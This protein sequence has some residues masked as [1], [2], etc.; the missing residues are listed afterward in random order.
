MTGEERPGESG[1]PE[2]SG[3]RVRRAR[4]RARLARREARRPLAP[5]AGRPARLEAAEIFRYPRKRTWLAY[6]LWLV[7]GLFGGHRFYLRRYGTAAAQFLTGGGLLVWWMFDAFLIPKYVRLHN[8]E[9]EARRR[10]GRPPVALAF[11]GDEAD[12]SLEGEPAWAPKR[13][14]ASSVVGDMVVFLVAGTALGAISASTGNFYAMAVVALLAL[15]LN[16][17]PRL[18]AYRDTPLLGELLT[19]SWRLRLFYH[20]VGPGSALSRLARPVTALLV[21][22]FRAKRRCEAELY[23]QVGAVAAILFGFV[24]LGQDVVPPLVSGAGVGAAFDNWLQ[25][26]ILTLVNIYGFAVPVGASLARPLLARRPKA[27]LW[28]LTAWMAFCLM[29]GALPG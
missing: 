28:G 12:I 2:D 14:G 9:Q 24:D 26:S 21:G 27:E 22:P 4:A 29:L 25:G 7:A 5:E 23:L 11:L 3:G 20:H 10:E 15:V 6:L 1:A 16:L 8:D 19:W 18:E 13:V 17:G